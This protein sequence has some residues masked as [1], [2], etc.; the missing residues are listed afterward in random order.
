MSDRLGD[1]AFAELATLAAEAVTASNAPAYA[2]AVKLAAHRRYLRRALS[3]ALERIDIDPPTEVAGELQRALQEQPRASGDVTLAQAV[4]EAMAARLNASPLLVIGQHAA[5]D[6][7]GRNSAGCVAVR[8]F[9]QGQKPS[10]PRLAVSDHPRL[11]TSARWR[12][13]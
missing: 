10:R 7:V 11:A 3:R 4:R 13:R 9:P 12:W 5:P 2:R 6:P 8:A 1:G